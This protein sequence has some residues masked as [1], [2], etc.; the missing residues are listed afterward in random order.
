MK[1]KMWL[2]CALI[3]VLVATY[4]LF[5][6]EDFE[7]GVAAYNK[8]DYTTTNQIF[9]KEAQKGNVNAQF[10][11]GLMYVRMAREWSGMTK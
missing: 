6:A 7:E 1:I 5:F 2:F 10:N 3:S 4:S 11:L 9:L 8:G